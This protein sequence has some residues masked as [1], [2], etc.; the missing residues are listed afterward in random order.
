[1]KRIVHWL[2][3]PPKSIFWFVISASVLLFCL[4]HLSA[5][6]VNTI[7]TVLTGTSVIPDSLGVHGMS[8]DE[9]LTFLTSILLQAPFAA[10][11]EE[12]V[13]R[14][15]WLS[16]AG[17][18]FPRRGVTV[19]VAVATSIAFGYAHGGVATIPVQGMSGIFLSFCYLKCGGQDGKF[20]K[21]LLVSTAFHTLNNAALS[22]VLI[23]S[24]LAQ[25]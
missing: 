8:N 5:D 23:L 17:M 18:I 3:T 13:F 7:G 6:A 10:L 16:V 19:I 22:L 9:L 20:W 11:F 24:L 21:P 12:L 25:Q 2:N 1:M 4:K 15:P 14:A